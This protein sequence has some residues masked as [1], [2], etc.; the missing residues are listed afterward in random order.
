MPS[1]PS[2]YNYFLN[3]NWKLKSLIRRGLTATPGGHHLY[4][5][6][7]AKVFGMQAGM[8][9]KWFR[10]IPNHVKVMQDHFGATARET[11]M[12]CFN[13]GATPAP[14]YAMALATD[15]PGLLT[16]QD[17]RMTGHYLAV[18]RRLLAAQGPALAELAGAPAD[19]LAELLEKIPAAG[20][21]RAAMAGIGMTYSAHHESVL[22]APWCG[23]IGLMFSTG[24]MEHYSPQQLEEWIAM[25]GRA[26]RPDGVLSH[27]MDHRDHRWHA[28]KSLSP[29]L[30]YTLSEAQ[31]RQVMGNTLDYHNRWLK[32]DWVR[33]FERHGWQV[34]CRTVIA[35]T[36]D[37]IQTPRELLAPAYRDAPG[38]DF[39]SLVTHFVAKR[40]S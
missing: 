18:S 21:E 38:G 27:V 36:P 20:D 31:F 35:N 1:S 12:W 13:C 10:V 2:P 11:V 8:A 23:T 15:R 19:R 32:G 34:T 7:T 28:D 37:L 24:T 33:F 40:R 22:Q 9:T 16:D 29:W 4:R 3:M 5:W 14:A 39:D 17:D 25:V 6:L 26:L 30:Q